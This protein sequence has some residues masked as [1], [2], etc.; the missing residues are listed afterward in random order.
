ML[1]LAPPEE[2]ETA[3][4]VPLGELDALAA[5]PPAEVM[6]APEPEPAP[7]PW[8]PGD[9]WA[10][11]PRSE[12][13]PLMRARIEAYYDDM[14]TSGRLD[15]VRRSVATYYGADPE[16]GG[17]SA[18]V[19]LGG[20]QGEVV[21]VNVNHYRS[22]IN[23]AH[24]LVT[25]SRPSM[26]A[27]ADDSTYGPTEDTLL[28]TQILEH[29][30]AH[31]RLEDAL[32]RI[33]L[34]AFVQG[35]GALL[36]VWDAKAG[37][38]VGK[39]PEGGPLYEGAIVDQPLGP[40]DLVRDTARALTAV[41]DHEWW[42]VR[43]ER[44]RF[45]L[46]HDFPDYADAIRSL[47]SIAAAGENDTGDNRTLLRRW[48]GENRAVSSD[49]VHVW[50]LFHAPT[51]WMPEGR[52]AL[53]ITPNDVPIAAPLGYQDL[54]IHL[55]PADYEE[56]CCWGSSPMWDLL[57]LQALYN[58]A[59]CIIT[60]NHENN[61][62][63]AT[64]LKPGGD[65]P[66]IESVDG[67][68][69]VA[70]ENKPEPIERL[71]IS[72]ESFTYLEAIRNELETLPALG[73]LPRGEAEPGS[74]GAKNALLDAIATRTY[75]VTQREWAK[76]QERVYNAR[77]NIYKT[78]ASA[79]RMIQVA[80]EDDAAAVKHWTRDDLQKVARVTIKIGNPVANTVEGRKA[81]ADEWADREWIT[82]PEQHVQVITTG[83]ADALFQRPNNEMRLLKLTVQRLRETA[84]KLPPPPPRGQ[85]VPG[86]MLMDPLTG[87]QVPGPEID[88]FAQ[89]V[90]QHVPENGGVPISYTQKHLLAITELSGHL[91]SPEALE[92]ERFAACVLAAV[93]GHVDQRIELVQTMPWLLE[94]IGEPLLASEQAQ[95]DAAA[96]AAAM[97][98]PPGAPMGGPP[99]PGGPAPDAGPSEPPAERAQVPGGDT[100]PVAPGSLPFMPRNP[101][102]GEPAEVA[103]ATG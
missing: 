3:V 87:A 42:I 101:A 88:A 103:G 97:M 9:Y 28:A 95:V 13:G 67:H 29:D 35:E 79:E 58:A 18:Y 34:V 61:G 85:M 40:L 65:G 26:S 99:P 44:N 41:Q 11:A 66:R 23:Q 93:Q 75:S 1:D 30:L 74:S 51:C 62:A 46:L 100:G 24:V 7:P 71:Q 47:P 69:F 81:L 15:K 27:Q 16:S 56:E 73:S 80:G 68:D 59:F 50:E 17:D 14:E 37:R 33:D 43:R 53:M 32:A 19:R 76:V 25:S 55:M 22:I 82:T 49:L 77:L 38:V 72:G 4:D 90:E 54:P 2:E 96:Q 39:S 57:S 45:R 91:N 21:M 5:G 20:K 64:W 78:F 63:Q 89:W 60:S 48:M 70:T 83:R 10:A 8:Q 31:M 6:P 94:A 92:D 52:Y 12:L 84:R 86:P 98:P 36:Q 102:T